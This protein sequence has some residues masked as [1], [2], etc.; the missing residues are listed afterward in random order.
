[1]NTDYWLENCQ[2]AFPELDMSIY[3]DMA[4]TEYMYGGNKIAATNIFFTNGSEDPWQ[5]VTQLEDR[6]WINQRS[7][8]STCTGCAHCADL[9]TPAEDD[10]EDLKL[11]R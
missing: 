8:V 9:Y 11:T 4:K 1:M 6:P 3:P 7:K 10:P 5:W 2:L